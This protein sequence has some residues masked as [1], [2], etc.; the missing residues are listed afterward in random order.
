MRK[1]FVPL[2]Q[3]NLPEQ[4]QQNPLQAW[5]VAKAFVAQQPQ[6]QQQPLGNFKLEN[7]QRRQWF[8]KCLR[9]L[10]RREPRWGVLLDTIRQESSLPYEIEGTKERQI[11]DK[12]GVSAQPLIDQFK[13]QLYEYLEN[14]TDGLTHT[15][16]VSG[17]PRNSCEVL[18]ITKS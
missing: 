4:P 8:M 13:S 14:F 9:F 1:P 2:L 17:G 5:E 6:Q 15:M 7:A 18:G 11:F 12:V 16:V 10:E 3:Q